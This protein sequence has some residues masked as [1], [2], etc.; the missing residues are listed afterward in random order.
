MISLCIYFFNLYLAVLGLGC[1][2]RAFSGCC[3]QKLVFVAV[4]GRLIP[5]ASLALACWVSVHG[6]QELWHGG[7]VVVALGLY[8]PEACGRTRGQTCVPCIG[9]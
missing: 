7:P 3:E 6:P 8:L 5:V 2:A 9:R 1:H 4:L